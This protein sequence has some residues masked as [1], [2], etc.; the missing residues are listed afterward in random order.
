M[1]QVDRLERDRYSGEFSRLVVRR[2]SFS[3]LDARSDDPLRWMNVANAS[4]AQPSQEKNLRSMVRKKQEWWIFISHWSAKIIN[5]WN[6]I[7]SPIKTRLLHNH[8][9]QCRVFHLAAATVWMSRER[10]IDSFF[11]LS[12]VAPVYST[13]FGDATVKPRVI[14][15]TCG[16]I[17]GP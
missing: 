10:L 5:N 11:A 4:Q 14:E 1:R 17:A 8:I 12:P 7:Q 16:D 15:S 2:F 3:E 13:E 9:A 6:F